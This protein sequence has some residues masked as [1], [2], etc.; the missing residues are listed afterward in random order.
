MTT[1]FAFYL[2]SRFTKKKQESRLET[3]L[4]EV[5]ERERQLVAQMAELQKLQASAQQRKSNNLTRLVLH[6]VDTGMFLITRKVSRQ[7]E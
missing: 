2:M 7:S 4:D 5:G 3:L 6:T 1:W